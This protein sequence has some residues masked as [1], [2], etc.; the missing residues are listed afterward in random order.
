MRVAGNSDSKPFTRKP[1]NGNTGTSQIHSA[2]VPESGC[3][4]P[5]ASWTSNAGSSITL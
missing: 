4:A 1:M 5:A 3:A 2:S